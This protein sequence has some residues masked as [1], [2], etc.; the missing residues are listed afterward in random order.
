MSNIFL[1][2]VF[3][4]ISIFGLIIEIEFISSLFVLLAIISLVV[5]VVKA[6]IGK[7]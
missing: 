7:I 6:G 1:T 4:L 5:G 2:G 3:T